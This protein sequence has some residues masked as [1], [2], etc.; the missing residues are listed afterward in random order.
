MNL[1]AIA[2]DL[3]IPVFYRDLPRDI[4]GKIAR[5]R[6]SPSQFSITINSA[7]HFNRQR[8]TLAHEIAHFI[9]HRD[10][11]ENGVTDSVMYRSSMSDMFEKQA[12]KKAAD[13]L[14]PAPLV[15]REWASGIEPETIARRF[16]VSESAMKISLRSLDL[17]D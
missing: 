11:I 17:I 2:S 4:V 16:E 5:D 10:L 3:D 15:R 14:M 13:I 6:Q 9:M 8:F 12:N 7:H 1:D